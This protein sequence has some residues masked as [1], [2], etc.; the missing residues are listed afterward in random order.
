M[1]EPGEDLTIRRDYD[2]DDSDGPEP[3]DFYLVAKLTS[4]R[5]AT[6]SHVPPGRCKLRVR[7]RNRDGVIVFGTMKLLI[8]GES[9]VVFEPD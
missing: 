3:T 8:T 7:G 2:S 4:D 6:F 9:D 1:S 5:T